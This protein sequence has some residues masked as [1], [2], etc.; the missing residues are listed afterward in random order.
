MIPKAAQERYQK[1][2]QL[3]EHHRHLY[4][5]KDAPELSDSAYDE[6]EDELRRLEVKHP[7]LKAADSPTAR[8]GGEAAAS[9]RKSV[10]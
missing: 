2:R 7:A 4:Y 8:V 10:G 3:V 6:L 5:V 9:D 1:L